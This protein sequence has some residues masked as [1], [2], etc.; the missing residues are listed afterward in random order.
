[1]DIKQE[2]ARLTGIDTEEG[3]RTLPT[4]ATGA[5][6]S[7]ND[8]PEGRRR[9]AIRRAMHFITLRSGRHYNEALTTI[10]A[11]ELMVEHGEHVW[12]RHM[13]MQ[14]M[15]DDLLNKT[16]MTPLLVPGDYDQ[17]YNAGVA[18]ASVELMK[19]AEGYA[20]CSGGHAV[21]GGEVL[22]DAAKRVIKLVRECL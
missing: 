2:V 14:K 12:Q 1:M 13:E 6:M 21:T 8:S 3:Q 16:P 11:A 7:L 5:M 17:G 10:Q 15:V 9:E 20:Q 19:M 18:A 22:K 4:T